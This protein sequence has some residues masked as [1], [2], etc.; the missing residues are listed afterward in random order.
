MYP[1]NTFFAY[2]KYCSMRNFFVYAKYAAST[3]SKNNAKGVHEE[4]PAGADRFVAIGVA[5]D[6]DGGSTQ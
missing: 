3:I 6:A 1:A 5:C 2:L 4:S